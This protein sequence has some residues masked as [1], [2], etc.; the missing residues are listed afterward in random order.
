MVKAIFLALKASEISA[1]S[2]VDLVQF[3]GGRVFVATFF[4]VQLI[5]IPTPKKISSLILYY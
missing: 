1:F 4:V 3:V 2:V 5:G